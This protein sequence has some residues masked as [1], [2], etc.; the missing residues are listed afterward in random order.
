MKNETL[1][2]LW[3]N[4]QQTN[5][6][7]TKQTL[8]SVAIANWPTA[9]LN[10]N[11]MSLFSSLFFP[12][13]SCFLIVPFIWTE[14]VNNIVDSHATQHDTMRANVN[15]QNENDAIRVF[16]SMHACSVHRYHC[17]E[18][19]GNLWTHDRTCSFV[20]TTRAFGECGIRKENML[21]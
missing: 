2:L 8:C 7:G 16:S 12:I 11:R 20:R 1:S 15:Q 6:G 5:V 13:T 4:L 18:K 9:S 17:I 21:F 3:I 10:S 19:C 14:N